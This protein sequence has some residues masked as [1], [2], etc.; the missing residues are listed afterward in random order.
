MNVS[1]EEINSL[2]DGSKNVDYPATPVVPNVEKKLVSPVKI[3]RKRLLLESGEKIMIINLYKSKIQKEPN[4][5]YKVL[6]ESLSKTT[7]IGLRAIKATVSEYKKTGTVK[8]PQKSPA[9]K[10][11]CPTIDHKIDEF[12]KTAIRQKIH[13]FWFKREIPTFHKIQHLTMND[14]DLPNI[15][16][17]YLKRVLKELNFKYFKTTQD[18]A[19]IEKGHI[20][21]W[22]QNY[23]QAIRRYRNEGRTIYYIDEMCVNAGE[24]IKNACTDTEVKCHSLSAG[25]KIPTA[26]NK[27]IIVAHIGSIEGFVEGGLLCFESKKDEINGDAFNEWFCGILPRL[28]DNCIIVMDNTSYHSV[29]KEPIP[30]MDWKK[31]N[32]IE[33]L[34]SKN[35]V[36]DRSMIMCELM[37]MV[38]E[39]KPLYDKYLIDEEALKTNKVVLRIPP[40]HNELNPL[41]LVYSI[42]KNHVKKNNIMY[43]LTDLQKLINNE[44]QRVTP[45]MWANF[46]GQ[47]I[48][49]EE[50]LYNVDHITDELLDAELDMM[51]SEE[52][53][54]VFS[55]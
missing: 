26:K 1:K 34:V 16:Q 54:S 20:V 23:I 14:S 44:V 40:Y 5:E 9:R 6:M 37:K 4:V 41:K 33:W 22:R 29:K 42:V 21:V 51:Q 13:S 12:G 52:D 7:G 30:T 28:K 10:K 17:T 46:V 27:F 3:D 36:I 24:S 50:K 31:D 48:K 8:S 2:F 55:V 49:E 38:D 25:L 39:I 15:S 19:L 18:S 35:C 43:E 32:I 11:N 47:T 45:D 53:T